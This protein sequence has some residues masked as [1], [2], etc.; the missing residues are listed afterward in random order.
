MY[1][2]L[3]IV[4]T[5]FINDFDI[6]FSKYAR[7]NNHRMLITHSI[8]PSIII[9]IFGLIFISPF[10]IICGVIY[11]IHVFV[12]TLDWGTN[13]LGIH[14]KPFGPKFLISKEELE[15]ID[16]ILANFKIKKSFFDFRYYSNKGIIAIEIIFFTLMILFVAFFALKY[17]F[18]IALYFPLLAF[19]LILY[20]KLKKIEEK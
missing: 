17:L 12:D 8:I 10:L 11:F 20:F 19:H 13:F 18:I 14:K 7:D 2:Y 3:I 4:I 16:E 5:A 6:L 9:L 15:N 1:E